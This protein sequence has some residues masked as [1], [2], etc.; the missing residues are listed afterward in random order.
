MDIEITQ[1]RNFSEEFQTDPSESLLIN[2]TAA[3]YF[4]WADP[5]GKTFTFVSEPGGGELV[6]RQVVGV[7]KDFH[8][9]SLHR[10]VEPLV[11]VCNPVRI[12]YL[13][14][15]IS[16][17]NIPETLSRLKGTWKTLNPQRP[18]DY[19]FLDT[20]FDNQ[21]RAE[22]RVG[23]LSLYFSLLTVF[24]GC[25]GLFGLVAYMADRRTKEIGIRKVLGATAPGIVGLLSKE[26]VWLVLIANILAW[27]AAYFGLNL[28]L[29]DFPYRIGVHWMVMTAAGVLALVT[30]L[31]TVSFQAIKAALANPIEALRYE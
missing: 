14:L 13:S 5:L 24:I 11:I 3:Q 7:V 4:N 20:S 9:T 30:A 10:R 19:F 2:E 22:E 21:Y 29:R 6:T 12:R 25:L 8:F 1:G 27:P 26:F 17:K 18:F 15:R 16:P 23:H 31:F 28:W